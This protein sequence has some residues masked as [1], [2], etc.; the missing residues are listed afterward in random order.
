MHHELIEVTFDKFISTV[1]HAAI[2]LAKVI[3]PGP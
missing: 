3:V 1:V 2:S